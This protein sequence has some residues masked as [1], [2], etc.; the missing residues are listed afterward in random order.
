MSF[1]FLAHL[2]DLFITQAGGGGDGD[3]LAA[4]GGLIQSAD[5]QNT[6]GVDI[7]GDFDLR[8]TA[9]GSRDAVQNEAAQALVV[10]GHRA[11]TLQH[12]DLDGSL[13]IRGCGVDLALLDRNCGVPLDHRGS[14]AAHGFHRKGQRGN[15]QQ[16][17]VLDFAAENTALNGSTDGDN[18]IWVDALA[19]FLAEFT[20]DSFL[21]SRHTGHTADHNDFVDLCRSYAGILQCIA[22]RSQTLGDQIAGEL[23]ELRA[24]HGQNQMFRAGRVSG[25]VRQVDFGLHRG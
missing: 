5:V 13:A 3:L 4:V 2:F 8:D 17:H 15:I 7:E 22:D 11:F 14:N 20:L 19:G 25:D 10:S 12:M 18:F 1:S 24:G 6:V 23:F 21:N 16:D 9:A